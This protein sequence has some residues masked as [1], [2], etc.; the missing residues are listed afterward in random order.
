MSE[1]ITIDST[2]GDVHWMTVVSALR[3]AAKNRRK[4]YLPSHARILDHLAD[5]IEA[6]IKP[7][8]IPEP[9]LWGV[10]E[11]S[12]LLIG[13]RAPACEWVHHR[14]GWMNPSGQ[15]AV[16]DG[17]INPVLVRDGVPE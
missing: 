17:L 4:A 1:P 15:F 10:V 16:W 5:Q 6:Q 3:S 13:E 9:G 14:K 11:A 8:R 12:V 7:P 2:Y